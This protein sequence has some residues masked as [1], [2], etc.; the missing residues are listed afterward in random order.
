MSFTR[1][2][3]RVPGRQTLS[4]AAV[5][6]LL[7]AGLLAALSPA[8]AASSTAATVASTS[9]ASTAARPAAARGRPGFQIASLNLEKGMSV[10]AVRQ[11]FRN[12]VRHTNTSV[13]GFQE[14]L[15]SRKLMRKALPKH[16]RLIM[17]RKGPTGV[18]DNPI[19]FN[20]RKW[21]F[22]NS[23]VKALSAHDWRRDS[24]RVA[25]D[26][27]GMV[28]VLKHRKTGHVIRVISFHL[29]PGIHNR[30]TG[31]PNW[32]YPDRVRATWKMS[33]TIRK[34]KRRAPKRQQFVA[35]CDCNVTHSKDT[36]DQLVK[37]K[38]TGPL[39]L[40]TNYSV[41]GYRPG[42]RI[43]YVMAERR[44]R[45]RLKAWRSFRDLNTDHP[46]IVGVFKRR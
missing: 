46:G 41:G 13:I 11:D 22:K 44:S 26:Q 23:W 39:R 10:R 15:F 2:V 37:G 3:P 30:R 5:A 20:M 19:A 25:H 8:Q 28:G 33:R 38:I 12:V 4:V 6:L 45:F 32:R 35:A 27:Y 18:D 31:G 7:A 21:K 42:W 40:A 36:G 16:W 9:A 14:R 43:D 29:P 17:A 24:G 1:A 34:V